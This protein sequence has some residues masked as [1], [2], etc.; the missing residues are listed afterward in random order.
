MEVSLL[1]MIT[2]LPPPLDCELQESRDMACPSHLHSS[3]ALSSHS[4]NKYLLRTH[5]LHAGVCAPIGYSS[6]NKR[7]EACPCGAYSL[8]LETDINQNTLQV[9]YNAKPC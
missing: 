6:M 4:F 7:C 5:L 9:N 1:L 2:C 3:S 8:A